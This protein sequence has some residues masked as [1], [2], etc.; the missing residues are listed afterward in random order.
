MS[1]VT[2]VFTAA[3][4]E[5]SATKCARFPI[6]KELF[7]GLNASGPPP[8][9][10]HPASPIVVGLPELGTLNAPRYCS[11]DSAR[12]GSVDGSRSAPSVITHKVTANTPTAPFRISIRS[13]YRR[14]RRAKRQGCR[15]KCPLGRI[16]IVMTKLNFRLDATVQRNLTVAVA[17]EKYP[18][19]RR[20]FRPVFAQIHDFPI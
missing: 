13:G 19:Q 8:N 20:L 3:G 10:T 6:N 17:R 18:L 16:K 11:D 15:F 2:A 7:A 9:D 14:K 12:R 1:C 5:I 4:I